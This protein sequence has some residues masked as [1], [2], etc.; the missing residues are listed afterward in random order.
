VAAQTAGQLLL[1]QDSMAR[2]QRFEDLN[3]SNG[4]DL[5][6]YLSTNPVDGPEHA[7]TTTP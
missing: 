7:L 5:K 6:V 4:P 2:L 1:L 3:T